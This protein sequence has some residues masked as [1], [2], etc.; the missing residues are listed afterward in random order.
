M[1]KAKLELLGHISFSWVIACSR[2]A[3]KR[4]SAE[5]LLWR[6][7]LFLLVVF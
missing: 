7:S 2:K 6:A 3:E 5:I 4:V 1:L